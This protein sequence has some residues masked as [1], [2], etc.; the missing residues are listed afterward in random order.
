MNYVVLFPEAE[1]VHLTKDVG[2]IAYV[3][4]KY[5]NYDSTVVCYKN[6]NN[7]SYL[8]TEVKGL[9]IEFINKLTKNPLLDGLIY[10][11]INSRKIDVL[12]LFHITSRRNYYWIALYKLLNPNGKVYLK[13]D[14]DYS[15][16]NF[17]FNLH[18]ISGKA[19]T[20]LIKL[21]DLISVETTEIYNYI[22]QHWPIKVEYIPN[23]FYNCS[24]KEYVSY[25][26]KE[27]IICTVGRIGSNQKATEILLKA[28]KEAAE[29]IPFWNLK[30]IGP[31]EEQFKTY[32]NSFF[33]ENPN[34][35]CRIEFTGNI[36]DKRILENEYRKCKIFC[37]TS[38][39]EGFP[40]VY[41]EAIKNGCYIITSNVEAAHDITRNEQYGRIFEIDN[42]KELSEA[43]IKVCRNEGNLGNMCIP[44]QEFAYD[45]FYWV[46]ICKKV[47]DLLSN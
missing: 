1:N 22:N 36:S 26:Y 6:N 46:N 16:K 27:N 17:K 15:I 19:K 32:I 12:Q 47:N 14:A 40:L 23:G 21:C 29:F 35:K 25:G 30:I 7:Y 8:D 11:L 34:L 41:L 4:H 42:Y 5:H 3:L 20:Y 28:F 24:K 31:I 43:L 2:M 37:L 13:L 44:I 39:W 45:N 9:K 18:K 33:N 10:L 38:R